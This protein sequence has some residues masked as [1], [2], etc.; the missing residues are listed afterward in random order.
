MSTSTAIREELQEI[1]PVYR[2]N[3]MTVDGKIYGF[4]DDGDVFVLYYR[5]DVL[6]DPKIQAAYKAKYGA[7]LPVP[8]KT[9]KEFDQVGAT[10][11]RGH[12]R[13]ALWRRLLPRFRPTASS[14][15]RS[16]SAT[17]AASSSI[18]RR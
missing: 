3:Q 6:G 8:P 11:H 9:W 1:A 13:Q 10:D 2:D 17:M 16:A 4:P 14:C 5:T 18:R 7:D 15:S 12:R